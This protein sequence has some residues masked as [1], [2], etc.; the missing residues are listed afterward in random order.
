MDLK[1]S[2]SMPVIIIILLN[3][4]VGQ[5]LSCFR[6]YLFFSFLHQAKAD[7]FNNDYDDFDAKKT[8]RSRVESRDLWPVLGVPSTPFAL[9]RSAH[10]WHEATQT[11]GIRLE[12]LFARSSTTGSLCEK[13]CI[14]HCVQE[15][16]KVQIEAG[17]S[18]DTGSLCEKPCRQ[19]CVHEQ[20]KVQIEAGK[21]SNTGSLFEGPCRQHCVQ[22]QC[23]VQ[24]EKGRLSLPGSVEH[25]CIA[26]ETLKET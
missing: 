23:K 12:A 8:L 25:N 26:S 9:S 21:S 19:H 20:C 6:S 13:P 2:G 4:H 15:Q 22:E 10:T 3:L 16:C 24:A 18:S 1:Y 11:A 5:A 14:P 17:K 7:C